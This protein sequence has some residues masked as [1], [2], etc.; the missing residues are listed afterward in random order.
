MK[1]KFPDL[2]VLTGSQLLSN[3]PGHGRYLAEDSGDV[4]SIPTFG[5]EVLGL[6]EVVGQD[7]DGLM[8]EINPKHLPPIGTKVRL[9]LKL[10]DKR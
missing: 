4:I 2:F 7:N 9:R 1:Q 8:W 5:D 10:L 3:G 6:P